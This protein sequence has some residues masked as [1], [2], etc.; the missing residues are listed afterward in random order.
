MMDTHG[1]A[2][3]AITAQA[4]A[5]GDTARRPELDLD[6]LRKA[7]AERRRTPDNLPVLS[8]R[9]LPD[10]SKDSFSRRWHEWA[11]E[12]SR[13]EAASLSIARHL[14]SHRAGGSATLPAFG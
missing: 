8:W 4:V 14:T 3:G 5:D 9:G 2:S 11:P 6:E 1:A 7:E 12:P 10:G 13:C